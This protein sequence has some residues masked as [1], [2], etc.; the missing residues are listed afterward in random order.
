MFLLF[1]ALKLTG[2]IDWSWWW[3]ASPLWIAAGLAA[4]FI[5]FCLLMAKVTGQLR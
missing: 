2:Y 1:M 5:G 3:V 4:M